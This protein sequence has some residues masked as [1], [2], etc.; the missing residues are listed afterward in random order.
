MDFVELGLKT[1]V[2]A[3]T[4]SRKIEKLRNLKEKS[5]SY[6]KNFEID[7][8]SKLISDLHVELIFLYHKISVR[9]LQH[10]DFPVKGEKLLVLID[11]DFE[12]LLKECKK[13]KIAQ[14]LLF[15]SK[16]LSLS[17][18]HLTDHNKLK[19]EQR[20]LIQVKIFQFLG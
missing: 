11:Q 17:H 10:R 12:I 2:K 8:V 1:N 13:N 15:L 20:N 19:T 6:K 18:F 7:S 9:I 3:P 5:F 14:S 4:N 16:A